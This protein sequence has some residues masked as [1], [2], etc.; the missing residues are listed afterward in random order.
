MGAGLEVTDGNTVDGVDIEELDS[1]VL[2]VSV[3]Q[4]VTG[5]QFIY[6]GLQISGCPV[7]CIQC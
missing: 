7:W 2:R 3:A 1:S 6:A 4:D 5:D